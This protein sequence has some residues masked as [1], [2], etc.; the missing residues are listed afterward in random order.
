MEDKVY[1]N[2]Q[3]MVKHR[4][5]ALFVGGILMVFSSLFG[6]ALLYAMIAVL[7]VR[8]GSPAY[9]FIVPLVIIIIALI[10]Y[11]FVVNTRNKTIE[12]DDPDNDS[13]GDM[14][15]YT[16]NSAKNAG[17]G[18]FITFA[19]RIFFL[20][21]HNIGDAS[22]LMSTPFKTIFLLVEPLA[23]GRSMEIDELANH[24][25]V[26]P[27]EVIMHL[28]RLDAVV[29]IRRRIKL[30]DKWYRTLNEIEEDAGI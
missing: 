16:P 28:E 12:Y 9:T 5:R 30:S 20:G 8:M 14:L 21:L 22:N 1:L 13:M 29:L 26:E 7:L 19:F 25:G 3:K 15:G 2:L 6:F 24:A 11:P 23:N 10:V 27:W 18:M 17:C 4:G